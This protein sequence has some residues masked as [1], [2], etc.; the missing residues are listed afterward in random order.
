MTK[1]L[2][3][4]GGA[5]LVVAAALALMPMRAAGTDCGAAF[6]HN[7]GSDFA[8]VLRT[9]SLAPA[10]LCEDARSGRRTLAV[11]LGLLG[12]A[13]AGSGAGIDYRAA[14]LRREAQSVR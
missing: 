2:I 7:G 5:A 6:G 8:S 4:L 11:T 9:N 13:L 12:V 1:L 10:A 14:A 3:V